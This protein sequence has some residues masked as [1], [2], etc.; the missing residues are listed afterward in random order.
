MPGWEVYVKK[1]LKGNKFFGGDEPDASDLYAFPLSE[2]IM[3]LNHTTYKEIGELGAFLKIK[4]QMPTVIEWVNRMREH[5]AIAPWKCG[6]GG[7]GELLW[8]HI[9]YP[10]KGLKL[11]FLDANK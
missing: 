5:K 2:R 1:H 11:E 6:G 4:E 3:L 9:Y 8:S 7:W 10:G